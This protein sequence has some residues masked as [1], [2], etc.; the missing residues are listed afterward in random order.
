M[1]FTKFD[2][3]SLYS[4]DESIIKNKFP[5]N[6]SELV[7]YFK[8]KE[9]L[10]MTNLSAFLPLIDFSSGVAKDYSGNSNDGVIFGASIQGEGLKK[11]TRFN[12][13]DYINC[14]NDSSLTPI[15]PMV[16]SFWLKVDV[17]RIGDGV[18]EGIISKYSNDFD[19]TLHSTT[20]KIR[21]SFRGVVTLDD[22][23]WIGNAI[24]DGIWH[25]YFIHATN[26][27][28]EM[29][30][31][32]NMF[33]S[34]T[35]TWTMGATHSSS[36]KIG[37]RSLDKLNDSNMKFVRLYNNLTTDPIELRDKIYNIEKPFFSI[38]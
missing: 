27:G 32:K 34:K 22:G 33:K 6:E 24:N 1:S 8:Q 31:D 37:A 25:H 10:L 36:F 13:D 7:E 18:F 11:S 19:F 17:N 12:I 35:G 38:S 20:N 21:S 15:Q 29:Y 3:N 4:H 28:Y 16:I 14:G 5:K 2:K 9:P 26:T 23:N 30:Q